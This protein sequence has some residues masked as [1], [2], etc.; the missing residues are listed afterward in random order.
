[1]FGLLL[2]IHIRFGKMSDFPGGHDD[3]LYDS[4]AEHTLQAGWDRCVV[5]GADR[6]GIGAGSRRL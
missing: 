4:L 2:R 1:M 6:A 3:N 5:N